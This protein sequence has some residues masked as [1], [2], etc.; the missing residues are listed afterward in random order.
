MPPKHAPA[1]QESIAS[2]K[3]KRNIFSRKK[4]VADVKKNTNS[5][6]K[7]EAKKDASGEAKTEP[8][9]P[10]VSVLALFR[11]VHDAVSERLFI[12]IITL[13]VSRP[14]SSFSWI[15]SV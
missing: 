3:P 1:D 13:L 5:D 12:D 11:L 6:E 2:Q 8:I 10:P 9:I 4:N 14:S 7:A 15:L